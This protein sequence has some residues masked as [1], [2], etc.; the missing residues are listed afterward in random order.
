MTERTHRSKRSAKRRDE[1]QEEVAK[2]VTPS[3]AAGV[4]VDGGN[5]NA[6]TIPGTN[7]QQRGYDDE[8]ESLV[9]GCERGP[10]NRITPRVEEVSAIHAF[11]ADLD[12]KLLDPAVVG[13]A[14]VESPDV[15]YVEHVSKWLDRDP[16]LT[17]SEVRSTGGGLHVILRLD[18]PIICGPGE[19]VMWDGVAR[20][21]RNAL[22][23]DPNLNGIIALTRPIGATNSKYDPPREVRLLRP[24]ESVTRDEVLDLNRRV[25]EQPARLWMR[26]F[27][28]GERV[29]PCPFC[30]KELL[31]VAGYWQ[32]RC[33][34]CGRMDAA[35]LL[36]RFF[37]PEFLKTRMEAQ[38]G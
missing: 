24:G 26:L 3:S 37:A 35:A 34:A 36:Y 20:G 33:Y 11:L 9:N 15:L 19:A 30:G 28:G 16:I 10:A 4:G 18:E 31:G 22:P 12:C 14:S 6:A 32:V 2:Q 38:N 13:E 5:E 17:K 7:T 29:S 23:G 21:V 1:H 25:T 27:F 8:R